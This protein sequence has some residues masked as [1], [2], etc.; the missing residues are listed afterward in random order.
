[1]SVKENKIE[2][3]AIISG[4]VTTGGGVVANGSSV[5]KKNVRIE[6]YLEADNI[7]GANKGAFSDVE[8]L[9]EYYPNPKNGWWALVEISGNETTAN[10]AVYL[11]GSDGWYDSGKI[12]NSV[13]ISI[14]EVSL[15]GNAIIASLIADIEEVRSD[16]SKESTNRATADDNLK[17]DLRT[18]IRDNIST[19]TTKLNT[20]ITNRTTADD[21]LSKHIVRLENSLESL[22][23]KPFDGFV[24]ITSSDI[25]PD[26]ALQYSEVVFNE[27]TQTFIYKAYDNKYYRMS[28]EDAIY[29][30]S[31]EY[32]VIPNKGLYSCKDGIYKWD[33]SNMFAIVEIPTKVSDLKNDSGFITASDITDITD[34]DII[35][36]EGLYPDEDYV[37]TVPMIKSIF[38]SINS[39]R[40]VLFEFKNDDP[41]ASGI[42]YPVI[43]FAKLTGT[44]FRFVISY[45]IH[46]LFV[47]FDF[48]YSSSGNGMI[49]PFNKF[50]FD[51]K[52]SGSGS[53]GSSPA[54]SQQSVFSRIGYSAEEVNICHDAELDYSEDVKAKYENNEISN[55]SNDNSLIYPPMVDVSGVTDLSRFYYKSQNIL[56]IPALKT[57]FATTMAEMLAYC[58]SLRSFPYIDTS[59]VEDMD[60]MCYNCTSLVLFPQLITSRVKNMSW[61]FSSCTSLITIPALDCH[62]ATNVSNMF[63]ECKAL[64][65][66]PYLNTKSTTNI[67]KMFADC[68]KLERI[69]GLDFDSVTDMSN[70]FSGCNK[71]KYLLIYNIGKSPLEFYNFSEASN[72]GTGGE[73]NRS[74]LIESL[75]E[76]SY[77]RKGNNMSTATIRLSADTKALLTSD[78]ISRLAEKGY[79]VVAY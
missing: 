30:E 15:E 44:Y 37:I 68:I 23:I 75:V 63:Y 73:L 51:I 39:N 12:F 21:N 56:T 3:D 67:K 20:E 1:M 6:G 64:T 45:I 24:A 43:S 28:R 14:D 69:E 50:I 71:L 41:T 9:K 40:R 10:F 62:S 74:S 38:G 55:F 32:G 47:K 42:V 72:W 70:I 58:S 46:G 59:S 52:S 76:Y 4:D 19:V 66:I 13:S 34:T 31:S 11:V 25:M 5:F 18:T 79:D 35:V 27:E 8:K 26:V 53:S 57:A 29:G 36:I 33:G 77:D 54:P 22:G 7:R 17:T 78:N 60:S 48:T 16:L 61:M 65:T 2:G 49:R